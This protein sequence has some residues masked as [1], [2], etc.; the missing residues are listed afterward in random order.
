MEHLS[1][2]AVRTFLNL[3]LAQL[4]G[5]S[6][7]D[8]TEPELMEATAWL[9]D[10][11]VK[12]MFAWMEPNGDTKQLVQFTSRSA[13][14]EAASSAEARL[15]API[16]SGAVKE[17][18]YFFKRDPSQITSSTLNEQILFGCNRGPLL[19]S[20]L[21]QMNNIYVP[22]ALAEHGWPDNVRKE[23]TSQ[24]QNFML[25]VTAMTHQ[26]KGSTVLYIPQD[27]FANLE[28]ASKDKDV[29]QRLKVALIHWHRQIKEVTT[30]QDSANEGENNG[31][32]DEIEFWNARDKNLSRLHEQLQSKKLQEILTVLEHA[33]SGWLKKFRA[34]EEDIKNGSSEAKENLR[35]LNFLKEPCEKLAAATPPEIPAILPELLNYVRGWPFQFGLGLTGI[36]C[37]V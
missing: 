21:N 35:F 17:F 16:R 24:V 7:S 34:L 4:D 12:T 13:E 26:G 10:Q 5:F 19:D 23:F 30:Q 29:V 28:V 31:P 22:V 25:T 9:E 11:E 37:C 8:L 6:S 1:Q 3:R 14:G 32:L 33:K 2:D 15:P 18:V 20:L 36:E 27:N